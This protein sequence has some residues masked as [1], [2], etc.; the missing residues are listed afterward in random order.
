MWNLQNQCRAG[1]KHFFTDNKDDRTTNAFFS[2]RLHSFD[3]LMNRLEGREKVAA[4]HI[5]CEK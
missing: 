2:K 5:G 1:G 3:C 4:I